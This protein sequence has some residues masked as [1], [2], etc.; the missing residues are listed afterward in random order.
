MEEAHPHH[1]PPLHG[2]K[3]YLAELQ[4]QQPDLRVWVREL[5]EDRRA[6][7]DLQDIA[8]M[9]GACSVYDPKGRKRYNRFGARGR[10]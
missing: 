5:T 3:A 10:L 1:L 4:R 9:A 8:R 6:G 2:R 7:S